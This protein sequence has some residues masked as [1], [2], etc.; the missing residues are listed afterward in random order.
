[1]Y[2][3]HFRDYRADTSEGQLRIRRDIYI[4]SSKGDESPALSH[5][6]IQV[7]RQTKRATIAGMVKRRDRS[8]VIFD[9]VGSLPR[10]A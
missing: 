9:R 10:V 8:Q 5:A 7:R 3:R 1:M 2:R 4:I 6:S